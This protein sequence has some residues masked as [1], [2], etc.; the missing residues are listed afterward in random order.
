MIAANNYDRIAVLYDQLSF[1]FFGRAQRNAQLALLGHIEPGSNILIVG[2]GT[3]WIL[4]EIAKRYPTG[5]CITYVEISQNMIQL[6]RGRDIA[7]NAVQF[8]NEAIE[9]FTP[10][11]AFDIIMT[12][13]L[14]DNFSDDKANIIFSLLHSW[15]KTGGKWLF[16]DFDQEQAQRH[17][18][19]KLMLSAMYFFF[20]RVCN[21][22]AKR[23]INIKP[24]FNNAGYKALSHVETYQRFIYSAVYQK[25]FS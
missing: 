4:Q 23:L 11:I 13:F 24:M 8:I 9:N 14:F 18:W 1:L 16:T 17:H 12:G 6:S 7:A 19:Q 22:E 21:V 15:L 3:G 20:R 25:A 10:T 2:G 5:L